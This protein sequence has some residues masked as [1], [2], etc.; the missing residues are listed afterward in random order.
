LQLGFIHRDLKPSNI[1][2][3]AAGHIAVADYGLCRRLKSGTEVRAIS[4]LPFVEFTDTDTK[5]RN[6]RSTCTTVCRPVIS[7]GSEIKLQKQ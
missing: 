6:V 1:L 4:A 2:I 5:A 7:W 3:D